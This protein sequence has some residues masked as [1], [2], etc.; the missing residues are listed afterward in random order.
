MNIKAFVFV[1]IDD[2]YNNILQLTPIALVEDWQFLKA[3]IP[4]GLIN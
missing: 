4:K 3:L 1:S 2:V